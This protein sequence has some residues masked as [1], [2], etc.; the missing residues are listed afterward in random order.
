MFNKSTNFVD[1][2]TKM[3]RVKFWIRVSLGLDLDPNPNLNEIVWLASIILF[4]FVQ[5]FLLVHAFFTALFQNS[6]FFGIDN[7]IDKIFLQ[8][9]KII[10]NCR[11][12]FFYRPCLLLIGTIYFNVALFA[13]NENQFKSLYKFIVLSN[14]NLY[15]IEK[16]T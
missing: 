9:L 6:F 1:F 16:K 11:R 7:L 13:L 8:A 4:V 15:T 5:Y 10:N 12:M 14:L 3:Y 2:Y